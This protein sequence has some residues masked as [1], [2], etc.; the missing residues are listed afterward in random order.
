[1]PEVRLR[2]RARAPIH[3]EQAKGL[4]RPFILQAKMQGWGGVRN[5]AV[6]STVACSNSLLLG[7]RE[8]G[9][10][11]EGPK[12][13]FQASQGPALGAWSRPPPSSGLNNIK[14]SDRTARWDRDCF[15]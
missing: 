14:W 12:L 2:T 13:R 3:S 7:P 8:P 4:G 6:L 11:R 15:L 5:G 10:P 9:E 1:M